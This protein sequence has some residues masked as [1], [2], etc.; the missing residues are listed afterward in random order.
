MRLSSWREYADIAIR[1]P[2]AKRQHQHHVRR[3]AATAAH[4]STFDTFGIVVA[5]TRRY[6]FRRNV[7]T[8]GYFSDGRPRHQ[9]AVESCQRRRR[10][11]GRRCRGSSTRSAGHDD[12]VLRRAGGTIAHRIQ[13]RVDERRCVSPVDPP[14]AKPGNPSAVGPACIRRLAAFTA[15]GP[16]SAVG[17]SNSRRFQPRWASRRGL[18]GAPAA[19]DP[20]STCAWFDLRARRLRDSSVHQH[21]TAH[22]RLTEHPV[23]RSD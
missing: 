5:T 18:R 22:F 4:Q 17:Q 3:S 1:A 14:A 9:V 11:P 16:R 21:A 20:A 10:S 8:H 13:W 7:T 12:D 6:R 23:M 19:G 15:A 2:P